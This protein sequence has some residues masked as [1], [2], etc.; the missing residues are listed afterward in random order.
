MEGICRWGYPGGWSDGV[1]FSCT[2]LWGKWSQAQPVVSLT[3]FLYCSEFYANVEKNWNLSDITP[4]GQGSI[5]SCFWNDFV[6]IYHRCGVLAFKLPSNA[7]DFSI[8]PLRGWK[9]LLRIQSSSK[10]MR[11]WKIIYWIKSCGVKLLKA[12]QLAYKRNAT[13]VISMCIKYCLFSIFK[14][15]RVFRHVYI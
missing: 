11:R 4:S 13:R 14:N 1:C 7:A 9:L 12:Y 3:A 10:G 15:V 5:R 2:F 8:M 6:A